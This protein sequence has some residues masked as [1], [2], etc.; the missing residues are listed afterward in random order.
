MASVGPK[1]PTA[2]TNGATGSTLWTNPTNCYSSD[3]SRATATPTASSS[4][5]RPLIATGFDFSAIPSD[6][7]IDGIV[8]EIERSCSS[9]SRNPRDSFIRLQK[10][11]DTPVG[12]NKAVA[13]TWPTTDA[14]ATYGSASDLW[15][16]TWTVAEIQASSFGTWLQ[17]TR[18]SGKGPGQCRIDHV[19]ITVYYT[20]GAAGAVGSITTSRSISP[21]RIF[22]GSTL[23]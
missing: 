5:T 17:C 15:G 8:L 22:G 9:T 19:R 7:T 1:S 3:D 4:G 11:N 2:V 16:T 21:G 20:G 14:Y 13:S 6:A 12:D 23:C 18:A 10:T